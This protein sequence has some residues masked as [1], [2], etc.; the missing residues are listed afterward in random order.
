M[1]IDQSGKNGDHFVIEPANGRRARSFPQIVIRADFS[2]PALGNDEGA[3]P[4]A[5]ERPVSGGVDQEP[6]DSE[7]IGIGF[8]GSAR[9]GTLTRIEPER[10]RFAHKKK[11]SGSARGETTNT[12]NVR[13]PESP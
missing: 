11:D 5:A 13:P 1:A 7:E 3:I 6:A 8:H 10:D 9:L 12:R 2:D 4:V